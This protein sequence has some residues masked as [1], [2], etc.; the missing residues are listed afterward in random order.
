VFC[1]S[2][3]LSFVKLVSQ[4]GEKGKAGA[5]ANNEDDG[6][7]EG[8]EVHRITFVQLRKPKEYSL[9]YLVLQSW[10]VHSLRA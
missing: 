3:L 7:N 10:L 8:E 4:E 5:S 9:H 1:C 6:V 2:N